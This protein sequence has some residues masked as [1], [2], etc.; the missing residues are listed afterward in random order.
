MMIHFF[1]AQ[2]LFQTSIYDIRIQTLEGKIISMSAFKGKKIMIAA[3]SPD[4]M[5]SGSLDFLDSLQKAH[6]S[7]TIIAVPALDFGGQQNVEIL[8]S[9][10]TITTQNIII[11]ASAQVKKTAGVQQ[12]HLLYWLTHSSENSH[13]DAEVVTDDQLYIISESGILYSVM[14][15][16]TKPDIIDQALKL[17]DIKQ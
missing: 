17:G 14:E 13:F 2:P 6:P 10:K 4:N 12:D 16:G 15:K 7:I 11:T 8:S 5:Q 9:L 3:L 1:L